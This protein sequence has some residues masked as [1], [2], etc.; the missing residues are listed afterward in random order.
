L[1]PFAGGG[2]PKS[3][4]LKTMSAAQR[5]RATAAGLHFRPIVDA[6]LL[7]LAQLHASTRAEELAV[8]D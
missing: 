2:H 8:T 3:G 4:V 6:D 1:C 5:V 7:F